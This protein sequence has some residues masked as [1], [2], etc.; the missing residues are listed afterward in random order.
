MSSP[1]G[2]PQAAAGGQP[3]P[4]LTVFD[5]VSM[6]VGIVIGVGIFKAPSIVAGNVASEAAFITLWIAGGVISLIGAL[7]YAELGSSH[8]NAGGEYYFLSR[9]YGDW[10]GFLFAWARMT[11]IQTGAIAAIAFVFG[12]YASTLLPLGGK[13]AAIYAALAVI[14]IT[15]LN[16]AGTSQS[17]WVQNALTTA[18]VVTVLALVASGFAAT[19]APAAPVAA[20]AAGGK[21]WFSGLALIFVL[22]TY[23]GWNEAAYLT[24][25]MRDIRRNIVRALVIG[26]VVITSLYLLLNI[27]YVR[28]LGLAGMQA[29]K[30]VA[31]DL[32]RATW[33]EGGAWVLGIV[34][35]SAA[36]S[37][38]NATVFTGAR[39]NYALGRDFVIFRALGRWSDQASAPV[40]ALLVQGAISLALV[41]L[42]SLTPDG[43]QTMVAYTAPAFWLFFLLTS[44]SLFL[45]RR[46]RNAQSGTGGAVNLQKDDDG[47]WT[48]Y[49]EDHYRVP[50]YPITP[51]LFVAAC[52]Y[53]LYSSFNY[54]MSLDPGSIGAMVGIAMLASGV[55]VLMWAR[56]AGAAAGRN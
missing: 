50:L 16:V 36:L 42:A 28:A 43:F 25:E 10:L 7:C 55:P 18:L 19:P 17:K 38:L 14:A 21:A 9:A 6:I 11:V 45:L 37:T 48:N 29:S 1:G 46:Q 51:L 20:A 22:L 13:S 27:A 2:V 3:R 49:Q 53:M 5:A 32:M 8:P 26:I 30:A 54:A 31:S 4:T 39:T 41:G 24:A 47:V 34:V 33:G 56:R 12:D 35:V 52:A 23:G 15:A 44:I 40:N